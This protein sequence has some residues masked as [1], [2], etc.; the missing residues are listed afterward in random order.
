M[1]KDSD[2]MEEYIRKS[3]EFYEKEQKIA[4]LMKDN[5]NIVSY[6]VDDDIFGV[7]LSTFQGIG[8]LPD[9]TLI[10]GKNISLDEFEL[11]KLVL[12]QENSSHKTVPIKQFMCH[13]LTLLL[14]K[15]PMKLALLLILHG[16]IIFSG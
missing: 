3:L 16:Q 11:A 15:S 8:V 12:L 7:D 10:Y 2:R 14:K 13:T 5:P 4:A 6:T 1:P 9:G